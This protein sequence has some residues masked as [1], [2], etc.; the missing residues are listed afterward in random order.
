MREKNP[1]KSGQHKPKK[2]KDLN[3]AHRRQ[4]TK[5]PKPRLADT[6]AA[7]SAKRPTSPAYPKIQAPL[8]AI[9]EE[10]VSTSYAPSNKEGD[11]RKQLSPYAPHPE[12]QLPFRESQICKLL[13]E[14]DDILV[15]DKQ[16]M[17]LTVPTEKE[18]SR[19]VMG[20]LSRYLSHKQ[21][22]ERTAF[23]V[24]RLDRETSGVLVFAKNREARDALVDQF[25]DRKPNRRYLAVVAGTL[26]KNTGRFESFLVTDK[27]LNQRSHKRPTKDAQLA[28]TSYTVLHRFNGNAKIPACTLVEVVL[29]TGRRNQIRAQFAE[30]DHPVIGDV[31]YKAQKASHPY[32]PLKRLALHAVKLGF[33]HPQARTDAAAMEFCAG[34]PKEFFEFFRR[35]SRIN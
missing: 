29:E 26:S 5:P 22:S 32:W 15:I 14:D 28:I 2:S 34:I 12:H 23:P 7:P 11:L 18:E 20:S 16:A 33:Q 35:Y 25:K 24:H 31:R 8:S 6:D 4:F 17:F 9:K 27:F 1:K 10:A 19:T 21:R 3:H 30:A 13:F